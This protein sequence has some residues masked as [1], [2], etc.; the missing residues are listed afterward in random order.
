[1]PEILEGNYQL[2]LNA[3]G[4]ILNEELGE[5]KKLKKLDFKETDY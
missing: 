3:L 1:M 4:L 5:F 2:D